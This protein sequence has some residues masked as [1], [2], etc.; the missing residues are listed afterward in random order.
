MFLSNCSFCVLFLCQ[1]KLQCCNIY[2]L[3]FFFKELS[4]SAREHLKLVLPIFCPPPFSL[5]FFVCSPLLSLTKSVFIT[6]F[7]PL[8]WFPFTEFS[9]YLSFFYIY[10]LMYFNSKLTGTAQ[11]TDNIKNMYLYVGQLS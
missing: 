9:M 8:V 3:I 6:I 5:S 4:V 7:R 1:C 2:V 10:S 11:K